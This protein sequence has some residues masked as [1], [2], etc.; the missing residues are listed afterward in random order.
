MVKRQ[1]AVS[2]PGAGSD[3]AAV[4]TRAERRGDE[5]VINGSKIWI[6]N[7]GVADWFF[8]LAVT[9]PGAS[10]GRRM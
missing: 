8:V 5:W 4:K 9:D 10:V 6:T 1:Y 3:V 2:E 7:G